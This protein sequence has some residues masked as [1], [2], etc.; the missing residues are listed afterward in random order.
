VGCATGEEAYSLAILLL[1]Y[2]ARLEASPQIQ[3]FASDLHPRS[4]ERA[5]EGF[6]PGDIE[7]DVDAERLRRFFNFENGGYRVHKELRDLVIFAPHNILVDPPFSR[8]DL[9]S[10]RNLLIYLKRNVQREVIEM[11]HYA[12]NPEGTLLLGS[13]ESVES[14]ELFRVE[15]KKLSVFVK[16]NVPPRD[17]RLP[18]FP[19]K[20]NRLHEGTVR[21]DY[22]SEPVAYG[23]LHQQ[24]SSSTRRPVCWLVRTTKSFICRSTRAAT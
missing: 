10:C 9:I 19:L 12:L 22:P 23:R 20:W 8:Q 11:F 14:S 17:P 1:E 24:M 2:A 7:T 3:V 21:L 13:A 4:L 16:R 15:D 18:L 5:R 6:Y